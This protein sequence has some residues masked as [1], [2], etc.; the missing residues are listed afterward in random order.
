M[1]S[2]AL[3]LLLLALVGAAAAFFKPVEPFQVQAPPMTRTAG[4]DNEAVPK[5]EKI[6]PA[7]KCGFC[8]G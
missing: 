1:K 2:F 3:S 7:R 8:M 6:T 4:L 5:D